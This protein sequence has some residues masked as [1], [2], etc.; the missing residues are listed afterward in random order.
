MEGPVLA[1]EEVV[2][3]AVD[4]QRG[5][6]PVV[7]LR[8]DPERVVGAVLGVPAE[9]PLE[10]GA[11]RPRLLRDVLAE[12]AQGPRVRVG[13]AEHLGILQRELDRA[14]APHRQPADGPTRPLGPDRER[15]LDQTDHVFDQVILVGE[16]VHRVRVPP[17][18]TVGH[19]DHQGHPG[20]VTLDAGP[21][22]PGRVVIRQAVEEVIGR[23]RGRD[24]RGFGGDH[25]ECRR[26]SQR[27]AL[28]LNRRERHCG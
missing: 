4:P 17:P 22:V 20:D 25:T 9:D 14:I 12:N 28:V 3:P 26:F 23:P 19:H 10:L 2:G 7:Q 21:A 5:N 27:P 13:R 18:T 1:E 11:D 16:P 15:P 24:G 8:D 6:P